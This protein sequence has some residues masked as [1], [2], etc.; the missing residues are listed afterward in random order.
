MDENS[1]PID[2][3]ADLINQMRQAVDAGRIQLSRQE[4]ID[5]YDFLAEYE[6][7]LEDDDVSETDL[8][9]LAGEVVKAFGEN[10]TLSQHFGATLE[11]LL[12]GTMLSGHLTGKSEHE[13]MLVINTV[14]YLSF[15]QQAKKG[16]AIEPANVN[17]PQSREESPQ[18][19]LPREERE[20]A[21]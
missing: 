4:W 18:S 14:I 5:I 6:A 13:K 17:Q 7:F 21:A 10:E 15:I 16:G 11:G 9:D 2:I 8:E 20:E 3:V 12:E 1:S 19:H